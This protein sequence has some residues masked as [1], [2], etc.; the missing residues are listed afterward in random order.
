MAGHFEPVIHG[1]ASVSVKFRDYLMSE[2]DVD[3]KTINISLSQKL[4]EIGSFTF[5]KSLKVFFIWVKSIW[6]VFS[7]RP[8][9]YYITLPLNRLGLIGVM[10]LLFLIRLVS[11]RSYCHLHHVGFRD[12][13]KSRLWKTL[14]IVLFKNTKF[15]LITEYQLED[16]PSFI[17]R[18]NSYIVYNGV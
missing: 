5:R 7:F 3:I 15:L 4:S 17:S 8:D 16:L 12:L 11:G 1:A 18:K 13:I 9:V 2:D 6:Y 10:P 14:C